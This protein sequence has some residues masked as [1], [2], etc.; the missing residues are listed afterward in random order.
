MRAAKE[1]GMGKLVLVGGGHAHLTTL[2]NANRI[3]ER[4]HRV[5]LVSPSA[6][7]YYS[8]MGPGMLSGMYRPGQVRF[9]IRK[10]AEDRGVEYVQGTAA[11]LEADRNTLL[12]QGREE[13]GYDV[14][15][16]NIGSTIDV[17]S[18]P[19][20]G[21]GIFAV[22]PIE[23]LLRARNHVGKL[24]D[25]GTPHLVVIGGG[26]A[27]LEISGNLWRLVHDRGK[28]PRIT[29]LAGRTFL[30]R[31]PAKVRR[32]ALRSLQARNIEVVEGG[33]LKELRDGSAM[34]ED[35]RRQDFDA[36]FLALGVKPPPLFC[37]SGLPT[38][39]DGGLL[40]NV[41]LQSPAHPDVFG[42]GDCISFQRTN[43]DKVGVYA[44]RQNPVLY[45]NLL[46]ALEG[47]ALET[48]S[49]GGAYMLIFNLGD[50][51]GIFWKRNLIFNGRPAFLIKDYID[52]T[53]MKRF[54]VSGELDE[55]GPMRSGWPEIS[56]E[57]RTHLARLGD[58]LDKPMQGGTAA[59]PDFE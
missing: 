15:S 32:L 10:T 44:V 37:D 33:Y 17:G 49:V 42:G 43:L 30:G 5:V 47:G 20:A 19:V 7:H 24:L 1:A 31:F 38:G 16:F 11:R 27:G 52:R 26:P 40:V 22:K 55:G 12:L 51:K 29:L 9:H 36:A 8:G 14:I 58:Q 41:H 56:D 21:E 25:R 28:E 59:P 57:E 50:G 53:F 6:Y 4:G 13:I 54:Q 35:G 45:H 18:L 34:L 2:V 23:E 46:A 48:F 39:S 3:V